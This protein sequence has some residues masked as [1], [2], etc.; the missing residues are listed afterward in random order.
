MTHR[1]LEPVV[2]DS[3]L[4]TIIELPNIRNIVERLARHVEVRFGSEIQIHVR[5]W[6][7]EGHI[8]MPELSVKPLAVEHGSIVSHDHI[9][10]AVD[11]VE[12]FQQALVV[13]D[14]IAPCG[15]VVDSRTV[16]CRLPVPLVA[17]TKQDTEVR[18]Q[19]RTFDVIDQNLS[20]YAP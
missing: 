7:Q 4:L 5:H 3:D 9:C 15:V 18:T 19:V 14:V 12:V 17:Y 11:L 10:L 6:R 13:G 16:D 8:V 2:P 20:H 1:G